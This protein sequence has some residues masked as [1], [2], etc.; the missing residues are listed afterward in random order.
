[1]GVTASSSLLKALLA[2]EDLCPQWPPHMA[3]VGQFLTVCA[4]STGC[5]EWPPS[6]TVN[7]PQIV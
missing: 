4:F 5:F 3:A 2:L 1:M 7:L 6:M